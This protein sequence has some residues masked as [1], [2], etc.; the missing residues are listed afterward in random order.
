MSGDAWIAL[1]IF[2]VTYALIATERIDRTIAALLGGLAM[3]V[4]R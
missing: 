3:V 4:G 1:A 2:L